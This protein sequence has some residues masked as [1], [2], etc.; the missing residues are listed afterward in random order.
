[1]LYE[2]FICSAALLSY[3][4]YIHTFIFPFEYHRAIPLQ[5]K[6][7]ELYFT[8]QALLQVQPVY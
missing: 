6:S 3:Y 4:L 2:D 7:S 5:F 1:M 8:S